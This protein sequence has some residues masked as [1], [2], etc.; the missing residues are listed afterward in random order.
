MKKRTTSAPQKKPAR[1]FVFPGGR[2]LYITTE[3]TAPVDYFIEASRQYLRHWRTIPVVMA[4]TIGGKHCYITFVD[5]LLREMVTDRSLVKAVEVCLKFGFLGF[6]K[7]G[8][9]GV[10]HLRESDRKLRAAAAQLVSEHEFEI[11]K[12]LEIPSYEIASLHFVKVVQRDGTG[13]RLV[14]VL[15]EGN[16]RII[17]LGFA[18]Y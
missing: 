5:D 15:N 14:G 7:G 8:R 11:V 10:F 6:S 2:E 3:Q 12:D 13:R 16:H 9:N 4:P 1:P 17:L 18:S